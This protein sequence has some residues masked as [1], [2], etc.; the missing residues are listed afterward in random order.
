MA[1]RGRSDQIHV[2][3]ADRQR[4]LRREVRSPPNSSARHASPTSRH[5]SPTALDSSPTS[6]PVSQSAAACV[7]LLG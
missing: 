3:V 2:A 6:R 5:A 7:W 1:A 4:R